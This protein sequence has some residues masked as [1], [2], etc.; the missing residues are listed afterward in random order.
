MAI[1]LLELN[2]FAHCI[3]AFFIYIFWWHKPYSVA[4]HVYIESTF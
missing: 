1:S 3:S 4:T 2:T